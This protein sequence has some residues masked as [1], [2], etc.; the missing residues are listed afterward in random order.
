MR[1]ALV[2]VCCLFVAASES[3]KGRGR[4]IREENESFDYKPSASYMAMT[5][6]CTVEKQSNCCGDGVCSPPES[7]ITCM[8]DCPGVTT[9]ETCGEE[10]H[11]DRSGK[12]LTFGVSY[13]AGSAQDCCDKCKAHAKGCNS[14]T[15]C[16]VPVALH[17]PLMTSDDL[18]IAS[19][20]L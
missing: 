5:N 17:S 7:E 13:R 6:M 12:G 15:F 16:G 20:C 9:H 18:L 11:S 19:D 14:W 8:A 1:P 10:P 2:F 4:R 3:R